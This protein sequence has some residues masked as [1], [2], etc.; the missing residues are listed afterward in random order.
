MFTF[1]SNTLTNPPLPFG[2]WP[3]LMDLINRTIIYFKKRRLVYDT[4]RFYTRNPMDC[5]LLL[6]LCWTLHQ[7]T[8]CY[9]PEKHMPGP[10]GCANIYLYRTISTPMTT[11]LKW[12]S[13]IACSQLLETCFCFH[14]LIKVMLQNLLLWTH[15]VQIMSTAIQD[16]YYYFYLTKEHSVSETPC[17][18]SMPQAMKIFTW[19][20]YDHTEEVML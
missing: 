6:L 15:Y 3:N 5:H 11:I 19:Y 16:L 2:T 4:F 9:S 17:I 8:H 1:L 10:Q 18:S 7:N 14:Y 20:S 12:A 13:Y